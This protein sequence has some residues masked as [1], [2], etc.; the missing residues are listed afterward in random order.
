[1]YNEEIKN[2][3]IETKGKSVNAFRVLFNYKTEPFELAYGKDLYDFTVEE[4]QEVIS[5]S[6][7]TPKKSTI[8]VTISR[9]SVYLDWAVE[10]GYIKENL[11]KK[12]R[13]MFDVDLFID[14]T[15]LQSYIITNEEIENIINLLNNAIDAVFISLIFYEGLTKEELVNLRK[16]DINV[17]NNSI[18]LFDIDN[19]V[20]EINVSEKTMSLLKDAAKQNIYV[21]QNGKQYLLKNND[22]IIRSEARRHGNNDEPISDNALCIKEKYISKITGY[23]ITYN[24]LRKSGIV[25]DLYKGFTW[26]EIKEK[27]NYKSD[28]WH[29]KSA[30]SYLEQL[31]KVYD[32]AE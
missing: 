26:E 14:L 16:Q 21:R 29:L 24:W 22:Y 7:F 15:E 20:R 10:N 32:M 25:Y 28:A 5:N 3:F 31:T 9:I 27:Y 2:K 8:E 30:L 23:T 1:M 6:K 13:E 4:L 19:T 11:I 17:D 12:Y 18:I